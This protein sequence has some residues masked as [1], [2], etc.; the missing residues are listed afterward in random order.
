MALLHSKLTFDS[1]YWLHHDSYQYIY[2][3]GSQFSKTKSLQRW[4]GAGSLAI[5]FTKHVASQCLLS[6]LQLCNYQLVWSYNWLVNTKQNSKYTLF[7]DTSATLP[8]TRPIEKQHGADYLL[9]RVLSNNSH[10]SMIQFRWFLWGLKQ[11]TPSSGNAENRKFGKPYGQLRGCL[12]E[13]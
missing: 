13:T 6:I 7:E 12:Y 1:K 5:P 4:L 10:S 8:P 11:N 3:T 2:H 9:F